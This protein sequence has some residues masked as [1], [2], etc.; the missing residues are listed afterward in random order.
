M[1]PCKGCALSVRPSSCHQK[2]RELSPAVP[3]IS[4]RR[5]Q[6]RH[7]PS[8]SGRFAAKNPDVSCSVTPHVAR[9]ARRV[10][11]RCMDV[12]LSGQACLDGPRFVHVAALSR[13][14]AGRVT[15]VDG[16][17]CCG[18]GRGVRLLVAHEN[19]WFCSVECARV[20]L[21]MAAA[22]QSV[23]AT[24]GVDATWRRF[25]ISGLASH[26]VPAPQHELLAVQI[27]SLAHGDTEPIS[28]SM[29]ALRLAGLNGGV[30]RQLHEPP[31]SRSKG[32]LAELFGLDFWVCRLLI[33]LAFF[34][35]FVPLPLPR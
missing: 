25:L 23:A 26:V 34:W 18:H 7:L 17:G 30:P 6:G 35:G 8:N 5:G 27:V 2:S 24:F 21:A 32:A 11:P 29:I 20:D 3:S 33:S 22:I 1:S 12:E 13:L 9:A 15:W 4:L 16:G 19:F 10:T 28:A 31:P 14:A